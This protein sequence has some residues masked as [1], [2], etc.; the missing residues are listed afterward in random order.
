MSKNFI[1]IESAVSEILVRLGIEKVVNELEIQAKLASSWDDD[2]GNKV[3][4]V[5]HGFVSDFSD[6][7][8]YLESEIRSALEAKESCL[9]EMN[10]STKSQLYNFVERMKNYDVDPS[11]YS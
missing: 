9:E 2:I 6:A 1:D 4:E 10:S 11:L 5:L 7:H 3:R 8:S